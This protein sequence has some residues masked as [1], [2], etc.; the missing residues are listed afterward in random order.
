MAFYAEI[1]LQI[2]FALPLSLYN[3]SHVVFLGGGYGSYYY[4]GHKHGNMTTNKTVETNTFDFGIRINATFYLNK[5]AIGFEASRSLS[6]TKLGEFVGIRIG[7]RF[8]Y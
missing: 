5:F 3:T 4:I 2:G 1:P 6:D 7:R 8:Y